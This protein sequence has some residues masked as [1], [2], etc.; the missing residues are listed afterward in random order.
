LDQRLINVGDIIY[1]RHQGSDLD[2]AERFPIDFALLRTWRTKTAL[3][4]R[5]TGKAAYQHVGA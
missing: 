4:V 5:G 3:S 1:L 2:V